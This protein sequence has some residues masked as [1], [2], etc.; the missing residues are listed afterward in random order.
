MLGELNTKQ[1]EML[2]TRQVTGRLGCHANGT[3]YIVPINYIYKDGTIYAHS[4]P[5]KKI[6]MMR[7][8]PK[9]CFEVD[10]IESIFKWQSVIAW[11]NYEEITSVEEQEQ[12][13]QAIIHRIMPLVNSPAGHPSHGIT[14]NEYDAGTTI[15]LIVYKIK[16]DK[17]TGKFERS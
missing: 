8:N 3:T 16:V 11:G 7:K 17:I 12:V 14:A 15:D 6:D 4:G 9:V 5:G 1:I 2:L 10:E 13:M